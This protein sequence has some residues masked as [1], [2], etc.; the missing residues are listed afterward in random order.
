LAFVAGAALV[1]LLVFLSQLDSSRFGPVISGAQ[2]RVSP[3]F[4]PAGRQPFFVEN[5]YDFWI[6]GAHSGLDLRARDALFPQVPILFELAALAALLP[7]LLLFGRRLPGVRRLSGEAVILPQL[8]AASFGLFLLAH[9]LFFQLFFP[10]RYVKQSLPLVLAVAAGLALGI[11]V[12]SIGERVRAAQRGPLRVGLALCIGLAVAAYPAGYRTAFVRDR[13]PSITAY[14][15]AQPKDILVAGLHSE[16]DSVPTFANRRVL[17]NREYLLPFHLG[18]SDELGRRMEDLTEAY[19]AESAAPIVEFVERYG[20]DIILV[21]REEFEQATS[22]R[23]R[24]PPFA[25]L[26]L[27]SHCAVMQDEEVAVVATACLA[28]GS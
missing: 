5:A 17:V 10:S 22:K 14:L 9:L 2:A 1:A 26:E 19:Y 23:E 12:E 6:A 27:A 8:L 15:R 7:L 28:A 21:N 24:T 11:L 20:V 13:H 3:D 25:L 4:G 18:Y 16:T